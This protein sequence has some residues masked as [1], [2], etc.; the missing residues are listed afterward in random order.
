MNDRKD[1]YKIL[2]ITEEE[3]KLQGKDF[4][5]VVKKNFKKLALKFHP[6]KQ[7]GKSDKEKKEAEEKFKD[8]NEAYEVLSDS[9]KRQ[10]Y[11]NPMNGFNG[12]NGF[13]GFGGFDP[14][15]MMSEF[16]FGRQKQRVVKGQSMR[17][18]LNVTL[19]ELYK[20]N[21]RTIKYKRQ[22]TCKKCGGSGKG[23]NTRIETCK[24][25]GGT[26]QVFSQN[27]FIQTITTCQ[28]CGGK[29]SKMVNPCYNC[30][31]SGLELEEVNLDITIPK[32]ASDGLQLV[33]QGQGCAPPNG[34]GIFGDLAIIIREVEHEVFDRNGDDLIVEIKIPVIDAILGCEKEV[35]TI[36]GK[37]LT[38]KISP[39]IEDGTQIRFAGKGMP[40]YGRDNIYGSM[41]GIIRLVM[42]KSLNEEE[43][44]LL[45]ELKTKEHFKEND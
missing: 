15:D 1:Y 10:E 14:F 38:T 33:A 8:V 25:C 34:E 29:G 31:G 24:H 6:D 9:Q 44:E 26:G 36:D 7:Q 18:V 2:G 41:I 5:S 42:P 30:N 19:E 39:L 32:G 12:F 40:V 37:R 27:G 43:K 17:I 45:N 21:T 28:H 22:G 23:P 13:G 3:K 11:D 16:G 20:G 4:E 35:T